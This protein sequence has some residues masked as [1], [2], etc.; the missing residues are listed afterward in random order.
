MDLYTLIGKVIGTAMVFLV[1][2]LLAVAM[3]YG[4]ENFE[5]KNPRLHNCL[6]KI[7][8]ACLVI[9]GAVIAIAILVR[10]WTQ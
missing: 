8:S 5:R 6:I 7:T 2:L 9:D 1:L 10:I 3:L 4:N